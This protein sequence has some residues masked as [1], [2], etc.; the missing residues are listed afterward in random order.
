MTVKP[1]NLGFSLIELMVVVSIIN[2]LVAFSIPVMAK[3]K[4]HAARSEMY[5]N[6]KNL[7]TIAHAYQAEN[8]T[9]VDQFG[10]GFNYGYSVNSGSLVSQCTANFLGFE[11]INCDKARYFY[12][13]NGTNSTFTG[14][15]WSYYIKT[16]GG[17]VS[18]RGNYRGPPTRCYKVFSGYSM[19]YNDNWEINENNEL[20]STWINSLLTGDAVKDCFN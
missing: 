15:A 8:S 16:T 7:A 13:Y 18:A 4:I 20:G 11:I 6:L 14:R 2:M 12:S 17:V 10:T 5:N 19:V 9:F 3:A 1:K